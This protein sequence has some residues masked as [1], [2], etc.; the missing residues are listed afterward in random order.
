M[1]ENTPRVLAGRYEVGELIGR[2]GMAEVHIGHDARLGRTVAIKVLRSDLARDPSFL[3]R[4]RRE[5]QS[6]AALNH[7]AIVAVYDTGEDISTDAVGHQVH[8]PFIVMEYV[9]GHTVRDILADGAAV[10]IE[11]A[12]EITVGVL[13]ALEYSHH[14]GIVHRDIKPANVMITPT[15]AVKV[16]D[17]GIARA[18]ADS[19]ATMTQGQG[20]IGTAQYLSPEQARGEQVDA[21]SD[22]YSTGCV[23]F[24]L[25]TGRPPFIGDSPV[26]LAYQ[27]VGQAPQRPS[28]F[29]N[30]VPEVLDRIVLTA[31][32]KDRD[33]RYSTA[34]DFRSDLESAM[35]GGAVG[36]P[37]IGAL[38]AGA[39]AG[40]AATQV[41]GDGSSTQVMNPAQQSPWGTAGTTA[42]QSAVGAGPPERDDQSR[43]GLMW[44]LIAVAVLALATILFFALRGGDSAPETVTVPELT[45]D[46]SPTEAE[47]ALEAVGLGFSQR[48]DPDSDE[49]E[50]TLTRSDP[51]SGEEV[52]AGSTVDVFFS[53]GP[54][55][56]GMPDLTGLSQDEAESQ[57]ED[58]G[59]EVGEVSEQAS[60]DFDEGEVISTDPAP[61]E[62]VEPGDSV[63]L[64]VAN[65]QVELPNLIGMSEDEAKSTL[66]GLNISWNTERQEVDDANDAGR[67]VNQSPEAGTIGRD[68]SVTISIGEE[69]EVETV[70][71]PD[72][73]GLSAQEAEQRLNSEANVNVQQTTASS[74]DYCSGFVSAMDPGAGSEVEVGSTVTI[75]VSTGEPGQNCT[76]GPT[77][78]EQP[79]GQQDGSGSADD[80]AWLPVEPDPTD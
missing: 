49:P 63:N 37:A 75:T 31:L 9:E 24:E 19:A 57:I 22:L 4:F 25:L 68:E 6:A 58:A 42:D 27:H 59:L 53:T 41:L 13:S 26:A 2:G 55:T 36:A 62:A 11:E 44:T 21:R 45:S 32:T 3:A 65:G 70:Q 48:P 73:V 43:K 79:P 20:V 1:V 69:R 28:E 74:A 23:L 47:R 17:F 64:T 78:E 34:A 54:E 67:V 72:V 14:A 30:D 76:G 66:D 39:A 10:P 12:V 8:I 38:A 60:A 29:A 16:M 80:G 71:L 52:E 56:F 50:N 15:G 7:P 18:V 33:Q 40:Y 35:R 61:R 5:A 46:M 77:P 51:A